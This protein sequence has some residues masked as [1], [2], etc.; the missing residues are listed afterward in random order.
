MKH[1]AVRK[2]NA[3]IKESKMDCR[4]VMLLL[5]LLAGIM[6]LTLFSQQIYSTNYRSEAD[7]KV[8]V[9]EYRSEADLFV[10]KCTYRSDAEGNKGMWYFTEY[11]S[12]AKKKIYFTEY[13]SEADVIVYFT[14]YRSEAGWRNKAK[15]Y[16]FY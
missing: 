16:L 10:Y 2:G 1:W 12:D 15:Q 4:K 6:P 14:E 9:T 8:Y 5:V 11:R 3:L 7:V 13:K